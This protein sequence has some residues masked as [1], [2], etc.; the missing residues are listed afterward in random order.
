MIV[1]I[2][3]LTIIAI[4]SSI[5]IYEYFKKVKLQQYEKLARKMLKNPD[6]INTNID[7]EFWD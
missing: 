3:L 5:S 1:I 2:I 6:R 7:N 4:N